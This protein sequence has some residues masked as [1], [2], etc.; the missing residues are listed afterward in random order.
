[1]AP[2]RG[3]GELGY[4]LAALPPTTSK[5]KSHVLTGVALDGAALAKAQASYIKLEKSLRLLKE[6]KQCEQ[7]TAHS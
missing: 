5:K 4:I 1:M 3:S 6:G 2:A 7:T